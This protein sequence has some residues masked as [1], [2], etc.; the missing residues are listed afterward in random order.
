MPVGDWENPPGCSG[1][2]VQGEYSLSHRRPR[3]SRSW[4]CASRYRMKN[5][6]ATA[7]SGTAARSDPEAQARTAPPTTS[8]VVRASR[9]R[10][11][12]LVRRASCPFRSRACFRNASADRSAICY[13]PL[14]RRQ[15]TE[16]PEIL[17]GPVLDDPSKD[18]PSAAVPH[19]LGE[20]SDDGDDTE[21]PQ[22]GSDT[23]GNSDP[24]QKRLQVHFGSLDQPA[25]PSFP[26][27]RSHR[28][29]T[30]AFRRAGPI[31]K[32]CVT[33]CHARLYEWRITGSNR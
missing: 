27:K 31:E 7:N 12:R 33:H 22:G 20:E 17:P 29:S 21:A 28:G 3:I 6:T 16:C 1:G 11:H 18:A 2:R 32:P 26:P 9:V 5:I 8:A 24:P 10:F 4:P 23:A 15:V 14:V 19:C 25:R 13:L 30:G